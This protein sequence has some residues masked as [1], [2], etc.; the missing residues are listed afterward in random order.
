MSE[1]T[2]IFK[3]VEEEQSSLEKILKYIPGY[4]GYKEKELR[5]ETD[6]LVRSKV[7]AS[8]ESGIVK[9]DRAIRATTDEEDFDKAKRMD[10][11]NMVLTKI[12]EKITHAPH[13]YAG[14][15]DAIKVK[16][17][18]LDNLINFDASLT[19]TA[20][21]IDE[22]CL[23]ILESARKRQFDSLDDSIDQV[24]ALTQ[25]IEDIFAKR[26]ETMLGIGEK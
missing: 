8:V 24:D 21:K 20:S 6:K 3:R 4:K 11:L 23:S 10:R 5:R 15:F 14:M 7:A 2:K 9:L 22:A 18:D 1:G 19:E 25:Q 13:G 16:E 17:D 12:A 26:E